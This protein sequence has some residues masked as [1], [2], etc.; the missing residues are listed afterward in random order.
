[1][2]AETGMGFTQWRQPVALGDA[3]AHDFAS[4]QSL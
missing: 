3:P 4:R 1:M 2:Q